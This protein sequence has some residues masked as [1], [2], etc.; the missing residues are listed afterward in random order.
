MNETLSHVTKIVYPQ[1][2]NALQFMLNRIDE[3]KHLLRKSLKDR[4]QIK[5]LLCILQNLIILPRLYLFQQQQ[6]VTFLLLHLM[7][8]WCTYW[9]SK[10]KHYFRF[11]FGYGFSKINEKNK[12]STIILLAI[13]KLKSIEHIRSK[14]NPEDFI[15]VTYEEEK[16]CKLKKNV[17]IVKSQRSDE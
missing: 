3:K 10:W 17:R 14:I 4:Q 12:H 6:A 7:L 9:K 15:S 11:L 1:L 13:S 5:D 8:Y 2:D 16:Y